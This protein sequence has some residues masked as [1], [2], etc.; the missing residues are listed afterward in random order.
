[1]N[2]Q[3]MTSDSDTIRLLG[4]LITPGGEERLDRI[5][6]KLSQE[7]T[8]NDLDKKDVDAFFGLFDRFRQL[9]AKTTAQSFRALIDSAVQEVTHGSAQAQGA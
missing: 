8:K 5:R 2:G 3:A 4:D 1:M 9:R 6:T 7:F